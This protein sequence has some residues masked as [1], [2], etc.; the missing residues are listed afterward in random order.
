V[1]QRSQIVWQ[2]RKGSITTPNVL[3][4]LAGMFRDY[5]CQLSQSTPDWTTESDLVRRER[6]PS[7]PTLFNFIKHTP[8]SEHGYVP[9][10]WHTKRIFR[11]AVEMILLCSRDSEDP[12]GY[13]RMDRLGTL[14]RPADSACI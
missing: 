9:I 7:A 2:L 13:R 5:H 10:R 11:N 8:T 3:K 4:W 1:E 6:E 14:R 12:R